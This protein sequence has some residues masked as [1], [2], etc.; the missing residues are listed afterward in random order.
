MK[1]LF[2]LLLCACKGTDIQPDSVGVTYGHGESTFDNTARTGMDSNYGEVTLT[3]KIG[4]VAERAERAATEER[5]L[6]EI[7]A[8][9][10]MPTVVVQQAALSPLPDEP[11]AALAS[12]SP[13]EAV[14]HPTK[15]PNPL[16]WW[17]LLPGF[18]LAVLGALLKEK[19]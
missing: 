14:E 17:P 8:L 11:P 12:T 2:L 19:H 7:R 9:P 16:E 13:C 5:Y 15:K 10:Q 3:W 1:Y 4:D 18:A 6:Q